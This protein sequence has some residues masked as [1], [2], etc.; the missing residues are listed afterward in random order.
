MTECPPTLSLKLY[1]GCPH[2]KDG[3]TTFLE[4]IPL[5]DW[6]R[7]QVMLKKTSD[8]A[9][10]I[11]T[12]CETLQMAGMQVC[13]LHLRARAQRLIPHLA[14][15]RS[16]S[17]PKSY[18]Q[19]FA[20]YNDVAC[21]FP[22]D[23]ADSERWHLFGTDPAYYADF[24]D[25]GEIMG[26]VWDF[27]DTLEGSYAD[28]GGHGKLDVYHAPERKLALGILTRG[29]MCPVIHETGPAAPQW[30]QTDTA[31]NLESGTTAELVC[32]IIA[33]KPADPKFWWHDALAF[34]QNTGVRQLLFRIALRD[35]TIM[36]GETA[37]L[38]ILGRCN[39][40]VRMRVERIGD[41]SLMQKSPPGFGCMSLPLGEEII[42]EEWVPKKD[43]EH[44]ALQTKGWRTGVY[45][46]TIESRHHHRNAIMVVRPPESSKR[47]LY[48]CA[49]NQWRS[50]ALNAHYHTY[51]PKKF[52]WSYCYSSQI[53]EGISSIYDD[54]SHH[55][56]YPM[57]PRYYNNMPTGFGMTCLG[58]VQTLEDF[59]NKSG[60]EWSVDYCGEEDVHFGRVQLEDYQV[61]LL[62][63]H[64]EYNTEQEMQAFEAYLESGAGWL[65]V[66]GGDAFGRLVEY[67]TDADGRILYQNLHNSNCEHY[68]KGAQFTDE[69]RCRRFGICVSHGFGAR[70]MHPLT[71]VDNEHPIT[72]GWTKD[73]VI[74][75]SSWESDDVWPAE[76][77]QQL[78]RFTHLPT[79]IR[80]QDGSTPD[81]FTPGL[82]IHK[83]KK[84]ISLGPMGLA[85]TLVHYYGDYDNVRA[86]L[87]KTVKFCFDH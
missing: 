52:P 59:R 56:R 87:Q 49:T 42:L 25:T 8:G 41:A 10:S 82:A 50:Y 7:S 77:W 21:G 12:T 51:L 85:E 35:L 24:K 68:P 38:A 32:D 46:V 26:R 83:Q 19:G 62:D 16:L 31:D 74:S 75:L 11:E 40:P 71:V 73:E 5:S 78:I 86:L 84:L 2:D 17:L 76:E 29:G 47:I 37:D 30:T 53:M 54:V 72:D 9:V 1:L 22:M 3:E 39:A 28:L 79:T 57:Q 60:G 67:T 14:L 66:L 69:Q 23:V 80:F 13:R 81:C 33:Y 45:R 48:I 44:V 18:T 43:V 70:P 58:F 36:A 55:A 20:P 6:P 63:N 64:A 34:S 65:I 4:D 15:I 27:A 61:V